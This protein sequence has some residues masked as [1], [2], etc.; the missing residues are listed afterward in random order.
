MGIQATMS[1]GGQASSKPATCLQIYIGLTCNHSI[2][3]SRKK[4]NYK[5]ICLHKFKPASPFSMR[6]SL[7]LACSFYQ[8]HLTHQPCTTIASRRAHCKTP[9][10]QL[11]GAPIAKQNTTTIKHSSTAAIA[12]T[13]EYTQQMGTHVAMCLVCRPSR[14]APAIVML[15]M[16]FGKHIA[17]TIT[18]LAATMITHKS[19]GPNHAMR[20]SWQQA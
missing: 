19:N 8:A 11:H 7:N 20:L 12:H 9:S 15:I 6:L 2:K 13:N 3:L 1:I 18:K 10:K 14:V 5:H 17:T 16:A 4:I